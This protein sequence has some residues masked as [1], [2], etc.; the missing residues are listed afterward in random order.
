MASVSAQRQARGF[1]SISLRPR[2]LVTYYLYFSTSF[3][4]F[5]IK[6]L[7]FRE[8]ARP[9]MWEIQ[10]VLRSKSHSNS[11]LITCSG[12]KITRFMSC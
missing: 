10:A 6:P 5:F 11:S 2:K 7:P 1:E 4:L 9:Y 12:I 3:C 8:Y